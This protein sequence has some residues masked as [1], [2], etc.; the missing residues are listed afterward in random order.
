M[1]ETTIIRPN[2]S[3]KRITAKFV[4]AYFQC[5]FFAVAYIDF[6]GCWIIHCDIGK[7]ATRTRSYMGKSCSY[8]GWQ[9]VVIE[10]GA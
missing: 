10:G 7:D 9:N 8:H 2:H 4:P 6:L 3:H 5:S 1:G